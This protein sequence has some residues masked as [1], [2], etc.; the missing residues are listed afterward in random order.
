[1]RNRIFIIFSVLFILF[2]LSQAS[3]LSISSVSI[4]PKEINPGKTA[5]I[6]IAID[7]NFG[8]EIENV[9]VSLDLSSE[10]LPI[11]PF[12]SST[13]DSVD[14]IGKDKT[15]LFTFD[16]IALSEAKPGV[17]KIPVKINYNIDTDAFSESSL[18]SIMINAEPSIDAVVEN[19]N[20]I[21]GREGS[22]I[23][24]LVN[25]GLTD[26]KFISVKLEDGGSVRFVS[27]KTEYI[28]KI[29]SNDFDTVEFKVFV[30][31]NAAKIITLPV[32]LEYRDATNKFFTE[33]KEIQLI[34][35]SE[36]EAISIGLIKKDNTAIIIFS[37]IALIILYLIYRKIKKKKKIK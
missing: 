28:D 27:T 36:D 23:L 9:K 6:Q 3:A 16:I 12:F 2:L 35:Y 31:E 10:T 7:N 21:H 14:K 24:K 18:I 29:E 8:K 17:Y 1:M 37:V 32:V 33:V 13:S 22:F 30:Q 19:L 25:K 5:E 4:F 34:T 11:A 15:K 20:L 26:L